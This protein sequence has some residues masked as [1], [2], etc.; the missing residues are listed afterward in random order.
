MPR[1][2]ARPARGVQTNRTRWESRLDYGI[3]DASRAVAVKEGQLPRDVRVIN[4]SVRVVKRS[5][6]C[7][8]EAR[9]QNHGA[10]D[11]ERVMV[12]VHNGDPA[13]PADRAG[14][15]ERP[16]RE[17]QT[18]QLGDAIVRVR[19]FQET[20]VRLELG[21]PA[22]RLWWETDCLDRHDPG[23]VHRCVTAL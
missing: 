11:A 7:W 16:A 4:S 6:R 20:P 15:I 14:A 2:T 18:R 13:K 23:G 1:N 12:V 22:T 19:G 21:A 5:G 8:V 9:L 17:L 10:F 3:L